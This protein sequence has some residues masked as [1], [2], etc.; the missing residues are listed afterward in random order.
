M[1]FWR[2]TMKVLAFAALSLVSVFA[3]AGERPATSQHYSTQVEQYNRH[4]GIDVAEVISIKNAQDPQKVDG[5]VQS[6]MVYVDH[7]GVT[8][9]LDYTIMGY[10]RQNG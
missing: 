6:T 3:A 2:T 8:H 5:P 10:G 7:A 4:K 1:N 9:T